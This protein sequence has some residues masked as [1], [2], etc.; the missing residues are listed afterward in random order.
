LGCGKVY[1]IKNNA[2]RFNEQNTNNLFKKIIPFFKK[3]KLYGKKQYD[4]QLWCEAVNLIYK[5][6]K[7]TVNIQKGTFG[8]TTHQWPSKVLKRL[9]EIRAQMRK[10]KSAGP[11][12]RWN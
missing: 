4:L 5:H 2:V 6:R 7:S 1:I 3:Y 9:E 10:Y 8:F 11:D 12:Y